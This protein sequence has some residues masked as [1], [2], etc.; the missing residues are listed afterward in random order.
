MATSTIDNVFTRVLVVGVAAMY[1]FVFTGMV[2]GDSSKAGAGGS[3]SG[4]GEAAVEIQEFTYFD[5]STYTAEVVA[6][7]ELWNYAGVAVKLLP[8]ES[9]SGAD[10]VIRTSAINRG[11]VLG[12]AKGN[13]SDGSPPVTITLEQKLE[14]QI[15][16]R[17]SIRASLVTQVAAHEFG[18]ALGLRR[19]SK[20]ECDLMS[21]DGFYGDADC[22]TSSSKRALCGPQ[23]NDLQRLARL[24]GWTPGR[25]RRVN[26]KSSDTTCNSKEG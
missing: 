18:H 10:I 21:S 8:A 12:M 24:Y 20:R 22:R 3:T 11:N 25:E 7:A 15:T 4:S 17:Q 19:H 9:A 14:G 1:G 5:S 13:V 16:E 2:I 6:A 23:S 26:N